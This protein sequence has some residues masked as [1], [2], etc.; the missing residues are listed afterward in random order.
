MYERGLHM[1]MYIIICS[2]FGLAI[3][4]LLSLLYKNKEKRDRG[5]AFVYY[6][7]SYRR[8]MIRTIWSFPAIL[9]FL[10]VFSVFIEMESIGKI[11]VWISLLTLF[12]VQVFY[13]YYKWKKEGQENV[14]A[15]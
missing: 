4:F 3:A 7:L 14:E 15:S 8:R 13:N 5:F 6:G 12:G 11:L 2:V 9:L 10:I 1:A